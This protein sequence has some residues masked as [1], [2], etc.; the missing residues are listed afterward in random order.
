MPRPALPI[1]DLP[2]WSRLNGVSFH[3]VKVTNTEG[4][5]YGVVSDRDLEINGDTLDAPPL[6]SV[7]HDLVLNAAAVE[8][9]AKEDKYFR[10][11]LDAIG[12]RVTTFRSHPCLVHGN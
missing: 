9:Y 1:E 11:L 7:P 6:L 2:A 4:K 3:C 10:Q 5:G 8:E 12:H